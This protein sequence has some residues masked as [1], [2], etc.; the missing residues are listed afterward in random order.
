[1]GST[2]KTVVGVALAVF[3]P[4]IAT[5]VFALTAGSTAAILATAALT[6][7]GASIAGSAITPQ[8]GDTGNVDSYAGQK[9]QTD[10]NNTNPV[11]ILYGLNRI[12]SNII[13]QTANEY[14]SG[15]HNKDY[16]SIQVL[17]GHE[18][19][20]YTDAYANE[21]EMTDQ[22]S[23]VFTEKN[24]H[25]KVH[26]TSGSTALSLEDVSFPINE[27]GDTATL[28]TIVGTIDISNLTL[29]RYD[30]DSVKSNLLDPSTNLNQ[31]IN[32][33][34]ISYDGNDWVKIDLGSDG[35]V[36]SIGFKPIG[37]TS[38]SPWSVGY[39]TK[40]QYSDNGSS[41]TDTG[42]TAS[43]SLN[44]YYGT[45]PTVTISNSH[46]SKHRYWRLYIISITDTTGG[47]E[48][49][50]GNISINS[51]VAISGTIPANVAYITTHQ[52]YKDA[53]NEH[54][55]LDNVNVVVEGKKIRTITNS[56]TISSTTSYS[57]NPAEIILDLLG[58][59]LSVDDADIDIA[60]FYESKT[61]CSNNGFSCNL[62]LVQQANIQS[63]I[64]DVLSTCRGQIVHSGSKWKL[65]IDTKSQTSVRTLDDDDFLANT[66]NISMR[67]N[68]EIANKIILKYVNPTDN[69][70]SAQIVFED[71]DLQTYDNQVIEQI[72][73][74]KG[75]TN[76]TQASKLAEITLN[77]MRYS[78]DSSGNRVKQ[79]PLILSFATTVKNADLEVGDIITID[80]D[81]LDRNRKFM[82]LSTETD[83]SGL[84]Q[85]ATREYCETHYK[86]SSGN[87]LI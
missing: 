37:N 36:S 75:V 86:D 13:Y 33:W 82:I 55:Q 78:E 32:R 41:W 52:I 47:G 30:T 1:M 60:S 87:Y 61:R 63:I 10:K 42:D 18:V 27:A 20:D 73:D 48:R 64:K 57:N 9:L 74:I 84:I 67:G 80:H 77:S 24:V 25:I 39:N 54:V 59:A 66:L 14:V 19:N 50:I 34:G 3:A 8:F 51:S 5:S 58:D 11:P 65:K 40:L 23:N 62:A 35:L 17:A 70:L 79:T 26:E 72:L 53:S 44:E 31:A 28:G 76:Q 43:G 15:A 46:T 12:A 56:T 6:L 7:A 22:G 16:W 29:S 21:V 49:Y 81:L 68:N 85:I 45:Y 2:V 71:T 69:W 83:Q 38:Y 4:T